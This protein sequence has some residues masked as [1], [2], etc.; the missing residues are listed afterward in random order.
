MR[1]RSMLTTLLV[2]IS[3]VLVPLAATAATASVGLGEGA[4]YQG[5][6]AAG[7]GPHLRHPRRW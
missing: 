4:S 7:S 2:S 3:L 5:L 6:A 1:A